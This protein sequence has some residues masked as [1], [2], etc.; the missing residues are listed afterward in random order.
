MK[1][2]ASFNDSILWPSSLDYMV[3]HV[4]ATLIKRAQDK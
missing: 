2:E 4:E 3:G 1:T